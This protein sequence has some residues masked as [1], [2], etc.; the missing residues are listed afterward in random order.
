VTLLIITLVAVTVGPVGLLIGTIAGYAGGVV[1]MVLMRITD[2][3]MAFPRLI[4]ALAFVAALK[5]GVENAVLAISITSW[6]PYARVARAET[7]TLRDS[8]FI[9]AAK[10]QAP[11]WRASCGATSCRSAC[12]RS[13]S[14]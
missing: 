3:F 8:E 2:I 4:L 10:L 6:P 14:A 7:I 9:M 12:P 1:D 13:S 11:R 5:P